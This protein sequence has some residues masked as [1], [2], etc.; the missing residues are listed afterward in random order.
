MDTTS[1]TYWD[2]DESANIEGEAAV[3]AFENYMNT[4]KVCLHIPLHIFNLINLLF[5]VGRQAHGSVS[6][7]RLGIL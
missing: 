3:A 5:N 1:G 6:Q 2:N 4:S 7:Q